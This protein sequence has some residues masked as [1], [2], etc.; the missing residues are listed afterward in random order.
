MTIDG[1]EKA[2]EEAKDLEASLKHTCALMLISLCLPVVAAIILDELALLSLLLAFGP[3]LLFVAKDTG[4]KDELRERPKRVAQAEEDL[5]RAYR[6]FYTK[7]K[8]A[9]VNPDND[10][11]LLAIGSSENVKDVKLLR[12]RYKRGAELCASKPQ[13]D[14]AKKK[15]AEAAKLEREKH[16][17]IQL[18]EE[19]SKIACLSGKDKYLVPLREQLTT[20]KEAKKKADKELRACYAASQPKKKSVMAGALVADAIAGPTAGL[21]KAKEIAD[22]NQWRQDQY[23]KS[24]SGGPSDYEL[25]LLVKSENAEKWVRRLEEAILKI[26]HSMALEEASLRQE[27][28]SKIKLTNWSFSSLDTVLTATVMAEVADNSVLLGKA[29][30]LDGSIAVDIQDKD[31]GESVGKVFLNAPGYGAENLNDVGFAEGRTELVGH[32]VLK[33]VPKKIGH[34]EEPLNLWLIEI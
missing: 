2:L 7:C 33:R 15:A 32:C 26:N 23:R 4:I 27:L 22:E 29:A 9:G 24:L 25:Q 10:L 20:A 31:T 17:L 3:A 12:K 1:A 28:Y 18:S 5:K 16:R 34:A 19:E 6:D 30:R 13:E 21:V 14:K 11:D 8:K